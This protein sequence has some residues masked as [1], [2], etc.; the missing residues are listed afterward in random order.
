M[1]RQN[2][3]QKQQTEPILEGKLFW[4][5]SKM[6]IW[7]NGSDSVKNHLIFGF[8]VAFAHYHQNNVQVELNIH[9]LRLFEKNIAKID[10]FCWFRPKLRH[11]CSMSRIFLKI[12]Q[13]SYHLHLWLFYWLANTLIWCIKPLM[14]S[15]LCIR[16]NCTFDT[17]TREGG[18]F[19]MSVLYN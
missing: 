8:F 11:M 3:T 7:F 13:K 12:C 18:L 17:F 6:R 4:N 15:S 9:Y 2:S 1:T 10:K 16:I 14:I 19:H 5:D